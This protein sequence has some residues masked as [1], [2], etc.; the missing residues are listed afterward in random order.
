MPILFEC[1]SQQVCA[2]EVWNKFLEVFWIFQS[3]G[4]RNELQTQASP[5]FGFCADTEQICLVQWQFSSDELH[6]CISDAQEIWFV[7]LSGL[8]RKEC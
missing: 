7:A 1:A 8:A 2:D 4:Q 6:N 5:E 3:C